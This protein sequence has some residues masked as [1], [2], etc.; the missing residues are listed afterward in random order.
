MSKANN[1]FGGSPFGGGFGFGGFHFHSGHE[2]S[3]QTPRGADV[4]LELFVGLEEVGRFER[5][6]WFVVAQFYRFIE[7][8]VS[9][10]NV[11]N[12]FTNKPMANGNA[13]VER[14]RGPSKWVRA[15]SRCSRSKFVK[16][17]LT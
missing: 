14:K 2:H 1:G 3:H 13:N 5:N 12:Q 6:L 16:N 15:D 17:A 11:S 8:K 10:L 9:R 7:A 4:V